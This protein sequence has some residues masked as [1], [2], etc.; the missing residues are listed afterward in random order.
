MNKKV[1]KV[2]FTIL[3]LS[4]MISSLGVDILGNSEVYGQSNIKTIQSRGLIFNSGIFS[5]QIRM[6]KDFFRV[7]DSKTVPWGYDYDAKTKELVRQ[8]QRENGLS[9]DG[10]AGNSTINKI[11]QEIINNNYKIGPR[12]PSTNINGEM[13]IINKSS[14]TLHHLK[15]GKVYKSY[16]VATGKDSSFTPNGKHKIVVKYKNP[17]WGGA[18]VSDPIEGGLPNNPLGKRWIGLS[19]GGGG[20]YGIHGNASPY[21]IGKYASAGCVRMHNNEVERF[22]EEVR[23]GTPVWI[24]SETLLESY[25][26]KFDHSF[27]SNTGKPPVKKEE[28]KKEFPKANI[29]LNGEKIELVHSAI[30]KN[31]TTYYPFRELLEMVGA[32]VSWD[33]ETRTAKGV[34]VEL[35]ENPE[36]ITEDNNITNGFVIKDETENKENLEEQKDK[37]DENENVQVEE[38]TKVTVVEFVIDSNEYFVNGEKMNLPNGQKP[39]IEKGKTYIPIRYL[40]EAFGYTVGWDQETNTVLLSDGAVEIVPTEPEDKI[41]EKPEEKIEDKTE[42]K[43]QEGNNTENKN[44]DDKEIKEENKIEN[45]ENNSTNTEK[46][47]EGKTENKNQ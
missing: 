29:S 10:I 2:I 31:G 30:N 36:E 43:T 35:I 6:I 1:R 9:A 21:S 33:A 23:I 8:F 40:M 3:A 26:V 27:G 16:A 41:E 14:N 32:E 46:Q 11:N 24:G 47:N 18:G 4:L 5:D 42:G 20:Q 12:E 37:I 38:N 28:V 44:T 22:Y 15:N 45:Q 17:A 39:F 19:V 34:L 13:I 7:R 25:G